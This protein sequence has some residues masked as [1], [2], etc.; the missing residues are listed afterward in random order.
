MAV[1]R[2]SGVFGW[3]YVKGLGLPEAAAALRDD[4]DCVFWPV[5]YQ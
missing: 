4:G 3:G 2:D 5:R 1:V